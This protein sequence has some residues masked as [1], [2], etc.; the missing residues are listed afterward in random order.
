MFAQKSNNW[1]LI[2]PD[3]ALDSSVSV[4]RKSYIKV[5]KGK[6]NYELEIIYPDNKN[7]FFRLNQEK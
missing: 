4:K 7:V 6:H 5:P 2:L 1:G 3:D